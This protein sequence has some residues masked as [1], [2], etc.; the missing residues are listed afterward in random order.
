MITN[1]RWLLCEVKSA[2]DHVYTLRCC[3]SKCPQWPAPKRKLQE[4]ALKNNPKNGR[5]DTSDTCLLLNDECCCLIPLFAWFLLLH[6]PL[7]I[8]LK[9]G[10]IEGKFL[11]WE[12]KVTGK[13]GGRGRLQAQ[14][15]NKDLV[16]READEHRWIRTAGW[17][18]LL[19]LR[20]NIP[21]GRKK[22]LLLPP[23]T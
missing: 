19:P 15:S 22:S 9:R 23:V 10:K 12:N 17:G 18:C 16:S 20:T 14:R 1:K 2:Q 5:A 8:L 4:Y 11:E 7:V 13:G 21:R 6:C 3:D